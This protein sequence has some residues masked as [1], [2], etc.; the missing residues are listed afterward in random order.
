MSPS[1]KPIWELSW[2]DLNKSQKR[3][4][5]GSLAI[6]NASRQC[7]WPIMEKMASEIGFTGED[8]VGS[9][10]AFHKENGQWM[11]NEHDNIS[12]HW[13][14]YE[15]GEAR[16]V[17]VRGDQAS[18]R[19]ALYHNDVKA[20]LRTGDSSSL[21]LHEGEQITDE[22]GMVHMLETDPEAIIEIYSRIEDFE[23]YEVYNF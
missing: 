9:T 20:F 5:K 3:I 16:S 21:K 6:L 17:Y 12:R 14:I 15:D 23:T 22:N 18:N 4:R 1:E 19:I 11:P 13:E 2:R 7:P 10:G 8:V